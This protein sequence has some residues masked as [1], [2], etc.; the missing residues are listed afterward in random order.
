MLWASALIG[1]PVIAFVTREQRRAAATTGTASADH[2]AAAGPVS[3]GGAR[4]AS[5]IGWLTSL[6]ALTLLGLSMIPFAEV[7]EFGYGVPTFFAALLWATPVVT[8]LA[9][10]T[11]LA[12]VIAWLKG[13]WRFSG[14]LHYTCVALGTVAFVWFL[15]HWNLLRF[16]A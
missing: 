11:V 6:V 14:R 5:W 2:A 9:A 10:V 12:A 13:Y 1:W 15:S 16:G 7:D 8:A 4:L 3:S